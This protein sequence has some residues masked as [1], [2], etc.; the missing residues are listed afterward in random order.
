MGP[1]ARVATNHCPG[2]RDGDAMGFPVDELTTCVGYVPGEVEH[3]G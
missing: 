3:H 1:F 2:D